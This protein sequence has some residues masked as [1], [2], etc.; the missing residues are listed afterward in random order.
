MAA[1]VWSYWREP[2]PLD[3]DKSRFRVVLET[4]VRLGGLLV[5]MN[6]LVYFAVFLVKGELVTGFQRTLGAGKDS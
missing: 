5:A 1:I 3:I 4:F 6:A 2:D